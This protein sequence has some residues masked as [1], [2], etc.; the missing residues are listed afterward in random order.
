MGLIQ[1]ADVGTATIAS[2]NI[3]VGAVATTNI[4]DTAA[5]G[6]ASFSGTTYTTTALG[7]FLPY[8]ATYTISH[9]PT[10]DDP[11]NFT[12]DASY[13]AITASSGVRYEAFAVSG[14]ANDIFPTAWDFSPFPNFNTSLYGS[15]AGGFTVSDSFHGTFT[16]FALDSTGQALGY[17]IAIQITQ[18]PTGASLTLSGGSVVLAE[19]KK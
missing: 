7:L 15:P 6:L 11:A 2:A 18:M 9:I 13:S 1:G 4:A 10:T 5:T 14:D 19:I 16:E 8:S 17:G 3:G 12:M